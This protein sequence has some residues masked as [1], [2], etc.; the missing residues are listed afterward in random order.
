MTPYEQGFLTKCA[1]S[2]IPE[3]VA[4]FLMKRAYF[5][6]SDGHRNESITGTQK[7]IMGQYT[8]NMSEGDRA[9]FEQLMARKDSGKAGTALG[10][11]FN[12][13]FHSKDWQEEEYGR[14]IDENAQE[15]MQRMQEEKNRANARTLGVNRLNT[16]GRVETVKGIQDVDPNQRF[17]RGNTQWQTTEAAKYTAPN[18]NP[19]VQP[20]RGQSGVVNTNQVQ[21]PQQPIRGTS[22]GDQM[23]GQQFQPPAPQQPSG[24]PFATPGGRRYIQ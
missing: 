21:Q 17:A 8:Q 19:N 14:S 15:V 7:D 18:W 2:G 1:E 6:D 9:R 10:R 23:R 11:W 5:W 16:G 4:H 24:N 20:V 22:A 12:R 13:N 3:E